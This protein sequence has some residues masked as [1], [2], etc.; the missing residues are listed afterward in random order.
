M[1]V[2]RDDI[3]N[4]QKIYKV[5]NTYIKYDNNYSANGRSRVKQST[6]RIRKDL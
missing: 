5:W 6:L 3:E 1:S 2:T 4:T